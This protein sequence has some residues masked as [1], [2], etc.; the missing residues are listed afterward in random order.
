MRRKLRVG[1]KVQ[2]ADPNQD[3]HA[4][5]GYVVHVNGRTVKVCY[6]TVGTC[7]DAD[8]KLVEGKDEAKRVRQK[9]RVEQPQSPQW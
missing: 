9:A 4:T 5:Y 6:V 3:H 8:L 2:I 7:H 1:D